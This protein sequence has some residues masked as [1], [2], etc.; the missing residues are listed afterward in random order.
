VAGTLP[1]DP[2][3][4]LRIVALTDLFADQTAFLV[5]WTSNDFIPDLVYDLYQS[6]DLVNWAPVLTDIPA[7]PL[8][9][10][11]EITVPVSQSPKQPRVFFRIVARRVPPV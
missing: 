1:G 9:L 11:T 5:E 7:T 3:S 8:S 6:T 2:T 10:T 4:C